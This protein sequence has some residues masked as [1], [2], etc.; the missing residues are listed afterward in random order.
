MIDE[1]VSAHF[2]LGV[3]LGQ[4]A[5]CNLMNMVKPI[6]IW[7]LVKQVEIVLRFR[8]LKPIPP[9]ESVE[10][11]EL[12]SELLMQEQKGEVDADVVKIELADQLHQIDYVFQLLPPHTL[13]FRFFHF[14]KK[15]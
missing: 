3:K 7:V 10:A 2:L 12:L 8:L 15:L 14:F 13:R 6:L 11:A 5:V 1:K 9:Y 4:I